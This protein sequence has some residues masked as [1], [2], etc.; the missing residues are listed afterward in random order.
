M[1]LVIERYRT[2]VVKR[3]F[4]K[5][6]CC[7]LQFNHSLIREMFDKG[8]LQIVGLTSPH[9]VAVSAAERLMIFSQMSLYTIALPLYVF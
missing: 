7:W 9:R 5:P 3:P 4:A 8:T 1:Y 2:T 6:N